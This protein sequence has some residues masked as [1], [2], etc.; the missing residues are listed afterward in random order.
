MNFDPSTFLHLIYWV[1]SKV[2]RVI[3]YNTWLKFDIY[4]IFWHSNP[5]FRVIHVLIVNFKRFFYVKNKNWGKWTS[6]LFYFWKGRKRCI[7]SKND[8]CHLLR[9]WCSCL[10]FLCC[11][12]GSKENILIWKTANVPPDPQLFMMTNW[13]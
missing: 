6:F 9:W 11:S 1:A 4:T 12:L 3:S 13:I 10:M 8:M 5:L 2:R 7:N